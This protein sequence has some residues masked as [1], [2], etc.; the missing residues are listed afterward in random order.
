MAFSEIPNVAEL[1]AGLPVIPVLVF[2]SAKDAPAVAAA[3]VSGGLHVLEV[4]LRTREALLAAREIAAAIPEAVVGVGSVIEA[5]QFEEAARIGAR[6]AVSPAATPQLQAAAAEVRLPW[7]PGAQTAS[8]ILALRSHGHRL[9]KFF[10]AQASGGLDF[11][12]SIAGPIPDVRFCPTGGICGATAASYLAL[13]NVSCVGGSWLTPR[14]LIEGQR[15]DEI[16][17]LA[18]EA[19]NMRAVTATSDRDSR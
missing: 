9:I 17:A 4:T 6:F 8:E 11:L 18:R 3:L 12:R 19:R 7:L 10:P 15:W 14:Y 5:A 16:T 13:P 1:F 2:E